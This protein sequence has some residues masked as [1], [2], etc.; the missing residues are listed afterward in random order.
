LLVPFLFSLGAARYRFDQP[1]LTEPQFIAFHNDTGVQVEVV[2]LV[3]KPPVLEEGW[4]KLRLM[5]E[6]IQPPGGADFQPVSGL[7]EARLWENDALHYGDRVLVDGEL[8]AP[9]EFE[10]FSYREYLA[11]QGV[12]SYMQ[13]ARVYQVSSGGGNPLLK[14]IYGY[15]EHALA[16]V[17]R[18]WPDP[19][20]SLL[21]GILLG[22]ESGID[23][24]VY[25][26]FRDTGTAHVIVIS[27]F[28]ITIVV[29]LLVG[30]FGR[31][32][33]RGQFG[34]RRGAIVAVAG[35]VVYTILVGADAAVEKGD[36][37]IG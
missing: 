16:T 34:V 23:E 29:G 28:N 11:R 4:V 24:K 27:G 9:P 36:I 14:A 2:G 19:E 26:D 21:A 10:D 17:Y 31:L 8:E 20:A 3:V 6:G 5:A 1:N 13:N 25:Q 22:E 18:L 33:G 37:L 30:V 15:K 7:I 35:I 12:Y 32:L